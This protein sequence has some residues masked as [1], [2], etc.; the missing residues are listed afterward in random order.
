MCEAI[1]G[2]QNVLKFERIL[3]YAKRPEM[4]TDSM[5]RKTSWN[6]NGCYAAQNVLKCERILCYAKRPE[7]WTDSMLRKTSWNVNGFYAM[8]NVL[9]IVMNRHDHSLLFNRVSNKISKI[10]CKNC[11][12]VVAHL[13]LFWQLSGSDSM[14]S[15]RIRSFFPNPVL[16]SRSVWV[17][18]PLRCL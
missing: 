13:D 12:V 11:Q 14:N 6:V 2:T 10:Y 4:W 17:R 8:Q 9:K 15:S 16:F 5:I 7:M 18:I 1:E 3:C